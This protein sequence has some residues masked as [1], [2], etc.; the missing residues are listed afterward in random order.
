[1]NFSRKE[2]K[3]ISYQKSSGKLTIAKK[4][5]QNQIEVWHIE[6]GLNKSNQIEV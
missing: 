4:L 2:Y 3:F 1:M 6:V 5:G